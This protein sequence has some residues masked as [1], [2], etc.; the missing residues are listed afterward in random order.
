MAVL[1]LL[2][3][4]YCGYSQGPT[5]LMHADFENGLPA[6]WT[7]S[8]NS[9]ITV[10]NELAATGNKSV[11]MQPATGEITITSPAFTIAAGCATRLEFSHIPMLNNENGGRVEVKK[12]NG[13]WATL[14]LQGAANPSCYDPSYG[15]GVTNFQ[16]TFRKVSYWNGNNPVPIAELDDSYWRNEIFYLYSTLTAAAT[17]VQIRFV[18]PAT[19]GSAAN[20]AGWFLD[21]VRLYVATVAGD[22]VRVPQVRSVVKAPNMENYPTC[23]DVLVEMQIRDAGG[24]MSTAPDA[25]KIEVQQP[26]DD[27]TLISSTV[28]MTLIDAATYTYEGF[29][30]FNGFGK[31]TY[32]RVVATDSKGNQVSYPYVYGTYNEYTIIRPFEGARKIRETQTSN[33]ELMLPTN[34]PGSMYQMRYS[35]EELNAAGITAGEIGGLYYNVTQASAGAIL[36]SFRLFIGNVDPNWILDEFFMYTETTLTQAYENPTFVSPPVGEHYIPFDEPFLWDG[37]S[38]IMIRTCW[39][40]ASSTAGVTKVECIPTSDNYRTGV[41]TREGNELMEPCAASFNPGTPTLNYKVNFKFHFIENCILPVDVGLSN[42]L[43]VPANQ[44]VNANT[45]STLGVYLRNDGSEPL[46]QVKVTYLSDDGNTGNAT[47]TGNIAPDDSAVFNV[48]TSMNLTAGFRRVTAWTDILPPDIDWNTDNDTIVY[49]IVSCDGAMNGV[50]AVGNVQGVPAT[51]TFEDFRQVFKYLEVCGVGAPVTVKVDMGTD[52]VCSDILKFPTNIQGAS[53]ANTITFTSANPNAPI[54]F[55]VNDTVRGNSSAFDLSGCKYLRFDNM[56]F[57]P[58]NAYVDN[59]GAPLAERYVVQMSQQTS[60][61]EFNRCQF[62]ASI[63]YGTPQVQSSFTVVPTALLELSAAN[64]VVIDSCTFD[65]IASKV[66]NVKGLSPTAMSTGV[67]MTNNTFNYNAVS[68]I[69]T[70]TVSDYIVYAEYNDGLNMSKNTFN[71]APDRPTVGGEKYA[72]MLQSSKNFNIN[73]NTFNLEKITAIAISQT[74]QGNSKIA[75]NMISVNNSNTGVGNIHLSAI[76]FLS[77]Q[78]LTIAYN[79]IYVLDA[80]APGKQATGLNLGSQGQISSN[81]VVNNN[82]VVSSGTG[83]GAWAKPSTDDVS[84]SFSLSN[85]MYYKMTDNGDNPLFR[86]NTGN[87]TSAAWEA[88][89]GEEA[90]YYTENPFF[91]AWNDLH[92]TSTFLCEKGI[93]VTGIT[94]DFFGRTRPATEPCIG[95]LEFEPPTNNIYVVSAT[96]NNGDYDETADGIPIYSSCD[97]GQET[98]SVTFKN[99]SSNTI[100]ANTARMYYKVGNATP[101]NGGYVPHPIE[102]DVDYVFTFAQTADFSSTA[103]D[104][105]RDLKVYSSL[106]LDTVNTNDTVLIKVLSKHQLPAPANQT[107]NVDYGNIATLTVNSND[108]IYWF[109]AIDDANEFL[110]AQTLITTE[111]YADTV[112]YFSEKQEIPVLKITELQFSRTATVEEGITSPL[113]S[114][115]TTANAYEISNFGN[116]NIDLTGY[117]FIYYVGTSAT[118]PTSATKTY[119]FEDGFILPANSSVVILP[120]NAN[121]VTEEGVLGL[122]TGTVQATKKVGYVIKDAAGNVVDAVALNGASFAAGHNVPSSVWQGSS[123][124]L[125]L[126]NT[127][128]VVRNAG[129]T[130]TQTDWDIASAANPMSIGTYND[131]LSVYRDNG[132]QGARATFT[133]HVQNAPNYNPGIVEVSLAETDADTACTLGAE[134]IKV[135]ISNMGLLPV[136]NI[137][138]NYFSKKNG[139]VVEQKTDTYVGTIN[140]FDTVEYLLTEPLGLY[141]QTADETYD[142]FAC[143]VL[144]T[145]IVH[146]NDTAFMQI[147]SLTTPLAPVVQDAAIPY[148]SSITLT[149]TSPYSLIWYETADSQDE[150]S[151]GDY[152]TPIL[153]ETDTFYVSALL[154]TSTTKIMGTGTTSN[155]SDAA[156]TPF[157]YSKKQVKEQYLWRAEDISSLGEGRITSLGFKIKSLSAN[158]TMYDYTIK[159]GTTTQPELETW[160]QGL[161]TVYSD[162]VQATKTPN[163]MAEQWLDMPFTTPYYYD[164]TSNLVVEISY[165]TSAINGKVKSYNETTDYT[166]SIV[167]HH[168]TENAAQYTGEPSNSY[169]KRPNMKF[170]ITNY[171]CKS[172][173]ASLVVNVATPPSC[174]AGLTQ[175]VAPEENEIVM[176]GVSTPI[177]VELKNFGIAPLTALELHWSVNGV[178]QT[179]YNWTGSLAQNATETVTIANHIFT[180]GEVELKAWLVLDCDD[181]PSNDT[182]VTHFSSCIGNNTSV[183]TVTIGPDATDDYADLTSFVNE[184]VVSGVCGPIEVEIKQGTYD[185][186][187]TLPIIAGLSETNYI[188]FRGLADDNTQT[189]IT[190]TPTEG[191]ESNHVLSLDGVENVHFEN[192]TLQASDTTASPAVAVSNAKNI[193]FQNMSFVSP[194]TMESQFVSVESVEQLNVS[195]NQFVGSANQLS[196]TGNVEQV[197]ITD[198]EFLE[199]GISAILANTVEDITIA[200]NYLSTDTSK[201]VVSAMDLNTL[202]GTVNITANRI[203]LKKGTAVRTGISLQNITATQQQPALLANNAISMIGSRTS[204]SALAYVGIDVD[205]ADWLNIYYNTVYLEP[206]KGTNANSK[207]LNI[208]ENGS[209][210]MVQN[211]NLDNSGKGYAM[212]VKGPATQVV[213]SNNNNYHKTGNKFV[214]WISD[215]G[216]LDLLRTA[217][218]MDAQSVSVENSFEN[219]S[220]LALTFPTDIVRIAEP[221]DDVATDIVG[222]FRPVSPKPTIGAY[223]YQFAGEDT[224]IPQIIQPIEGDEYVEGDPL[225]VEV[226]LKNFGNYS[227]NSVEITAVLKSSRDSQTPIQTLTETWTGMLASLQ[228]TTYTFNQTFTPPLNTPYTEDLWVM[229]YTSMTGDTVEMNDTAYT[230][231]LS[232]PAKDLKILSQK[233]LPETRCELRQVQVL[234]GIKNIGEKIIDANDAVQVSYWIEDRPDILVTETLTFPYTDPTTG[235]TFQSLQPGA[236]LTYAFNQTSDLYPLGDSDVQWKLWSCVKT[237]GD[238]QQD[239]DTATSAKTVYSKVSPPAPTVTDDYIPYATWG[240]PRAEQENNLLIKWYSSATAQDPF[241]VAQNYNASKVYTT[242]QLFADTTF[243]VGVN[244]ANAQYPCASERTPVTVY[245]DE[246]A[247]IDAS[248]VA[249]V[250]P[251]A[252]AWIYM[253]TG[254]TIKVELTNF[255]TQPISNIPVSYSIRKTSDAASAAIVVSEICTVTIQPDQHYI[256]SFDSLAD[257]SQANK[258]YVVRAWTDMNGDYTALN[259]TTNA[260]TIKPISS[261]YPPMNGGN[262]ESLDISRV[263]LATMDHP[264]TPSGNTYTSYAAD[265][266]LVPVLYKGV[267]DR[268]NVYVDNSTPMD[269]LSV[270]GGWLKVYIDWNR[271]AQFEDTE[272]VMSDTAY[273]GSIVSGVIN[274]PANTIN[275]QTGMRVM[276]K[277]YAAS[278]DEDFNATNTIGAGEVEDYKVFVK[279]AKDVNAELKRFVSPVEMASEGQTNVTVIL[280]NAGLQPLNSATISWMFNEQ[281]QAQFN[282]TGNLASGAIDT[283]TI[284]QVDLTLGMNYFKA[285]V[286][287]ANDEDHENDTASVGSY[288][289]RTFTIPYSTNFDEETPNDHFYAYN[290]SL[291]NPTNCWEMGTPAATNTTIN[292]AY[293]DPN[294]WK[295]DLDDKAPKNNESILYSPIFDVNIVKPDT[296]SFMLRRDNTVGNARMYVEYLNWEGKWVL[297]GSSEDEFADN[298][299]NN[300]ENFFEGSRSWTKVSYSLNHLNYMFGNKLQFRFVFRSKNSTQKD[301]FAIDDFEIKRAKRDQDAG[302]VS[303]TL[304]PTALPNYGSDYFPKVGIKNYGAQTLTDV[305]VCY[306]SEGMYIPICENLLNVNIEPD[307]VYEYTFTTGTY[308]TVD[309]PDP[310]GICAFTRLNPTDVYSD[311]D[312]LCQDIVIGPLQKDVGIVSINSPT[313]QIVSNDQ[314]EVAIQIRNYGLDPVSE[315]PV[316]YTV[317]GGTQVVETIY[318]NPPLYNGDEYVY[319]FNQTF[320]SSFGSVNLKC[321]TGLEGDF[322][323]DNDTIYKRLEGMGTIKDLEAKYVTIDDADPDNIGLQLAVM[324]RSS[325]GIGE[326]TVGYFINGDRDNMVVET[327]R[328]GTVLP[329][330]AYGYHKFEAMLPR[331]NAPYTRI[332]AFVSVDDENDR[333][334]D[335]TSVLYMG[336]R[337]GVADSIFIEQTYESECKVQLTAHNGGTIGGTTQVRAHLVLNGDFANQ[338]VEDFTWTFDEPNPALTRYMTFTQKIPRSES[339]TYDVLAWIEYPYDADH[340]N[341]STRASAVRSF[342]GLEDVEAEAGFELEQNQ[343]NPFSDQ[344]VIG[345]TLPEAGEATL[346]ISNNLGQVLKTI[347]GVYGSGRS[348]ITLKDLDLPEGVY[349][350]TMYYNDQKQVR[351]M[352]I[353]R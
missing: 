136:S 193:S 108:S 20:F 189:I 140:P 288:V 137:P 177:Q 176:S 180:S 283:V 16:G 342:V 147:L 232:V 213:L 292:A 167:F 282:W 62:P 295:T 247:D 203:Y 182:T 340:R 352:I 97:F 120:V 266:N 80:G 304:E 83:Y 72:V 124:N 6:G 303:L 57:L 210:I 41:H 23:S 345:F 211:N 178:E 149:A 42:T 30:P 243:Y 4:S 325:V 319:R 259:D 219:D 112:F 119:S 175:V 313:T 152:E 215:K 133:V 183:T 346:T 297:L 227:I 81:V 348:T 141:A 27:G 76:K 138:I 173:R 172:E 33:Q 46:T 201:Y 254:D 230:S 250:E 344:T 275:G 67:T 159:L 28:N 218:S 279:S 329:A 1:F 217:N 271:N 253:L 339:G 111:L 222:N 127:A 324:N 268:M 3:L 87:V 199:F 13:Q 191:V 157:A 280:R 100:A 302:V 276:L 78:G 270:S 7:V 93:S 184:L 190:Y 224:G 272:C 166:S 145:D 267:S 265:S 98:I 332:T 144:P 165:N 221:I 186:Q 318:F 238:N 349:H 126:S 294:C 92:S 233:T 14:T 322:Y 316:A 305:Q 150:L 198:N 174:E 116:G 326:I 181:E 171:G 47:W 59:T 74:I 139:V 311:N 148:A 121:S 296:M 315:L 115:V 256:Y 320:H 63:T 298:W 244:A 281:V 34:K 188:K 15:S 255:G 307:Q 104:V 168:N 353:V 9:N 257:M 246:R 338:I 337:D 335:T 261:G 314:I 84:L 249:I 323:H 160:I 82:I 117:K 236:D 40:I 312:S 71:S 73:K 22:E 207:C 85:N 90:S 99:I 21:D 129:T 45:N 241:Y 242:S 194:K 39:G 161:Q 101:I 252:S 327:Y 228:S 209:N 128:G 308:L 306:V 125:S 88:M 43:A 143:T 293:S 274:V 351:K 206:S 151:R 105:T 2:F 248:A 290:A 225:T 66:I 89:S 264:T 114:W 260:L 130:G 216:T 123:A 91:G 234:V 284:G 24:A 118:L 65:N 113:P 200:N 334:N 107:I 146:D 153:Y 205:N 214:Y 286:D 204:S 156:P 187:I 212:Y 131:N 54:K 122:G 75:N 38:D 251:P 56:I 289:F 192:L 19:S 350:Y 220:T 330:G 10:Y 48:T 309:A 69:G 31:K 142:I 229:V 162:T 109:K 8:S 132:C 277:Q 36:P 202:S 299:Y 79:N 262:P 18:L 154:E 26:D 185:E 278:S 321:W 70:P 285:Y 158:I 55:Y 208:S 170:G 110:K 134:Q 343:P 169:E 269:P 235:T 333:T 317:P 163:D 231:F 328:E 197:T 331:A 64:N 336:Y 196:L 106:T 49:E 102:P 347:K 273:T 94:D 179:V 58:A 5:L 103:I 300:E 155:T 61:I 226:E 239:N 68:V 341:D 240:H 195:A 12:P 32:W 35:A 86:I 51:R 245:L 258:N 60:N 310:F 135:K 77:G 11:R 291:S 287:I 37:V 237:V 301:G 95:A 164:G 263:Q 223:E 96:L 52:G 44:K 50:Y 17:E 53:A 29:I 25:V